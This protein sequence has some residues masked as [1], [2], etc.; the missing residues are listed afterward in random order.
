MASAE[1][2]NLPI[3]SPLITDQQYYP[4]VIHGRET[5]KDLAESSAL[6]QAI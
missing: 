1:W 4:K 5:E 6:S 2:L 3:E